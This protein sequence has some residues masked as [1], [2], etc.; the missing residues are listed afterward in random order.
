MNEFIIHDGKPYLYHNGKTFGVRWDEHGFTVGNEVKLTGFSTRTYSEVSV[1][2]KCECLDSITE[3][4][5]ETE[6]KPKRRKKAD[7]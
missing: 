1:K 5:P 2:A 7:N 6:E 4:E 3:P